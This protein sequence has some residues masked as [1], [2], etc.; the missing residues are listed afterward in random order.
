MKTGVA[1]GWL[2]SNYFSSVDLRSFAVEMNSTGME[3]VEPFLR[4]SLLVLIFLTPGKLDL[5]F[6]RQCLEEGEKAV[7]LESS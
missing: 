5:L 1:R 7:A 2:T 3:A 4:L 6:I